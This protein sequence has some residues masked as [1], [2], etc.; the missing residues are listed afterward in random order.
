MCYRRFHLIR[1]L[2][3]QVKILED[4][5]KGCQLCVHVCPK[6]LLKLSSRTNERG[7]FI[8]EWED[9]GCIGCGLCYVICPEQTIRIYAKIENG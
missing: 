9:M 2:L 6:H 4:G 3:Y 8:V 5:C 1:P 7:Y